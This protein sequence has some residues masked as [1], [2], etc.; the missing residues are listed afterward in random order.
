MTPP[1]RKGRYSI[2]TGHLFLYRC[3]TLCAS[4]ENGDMQSKKNSSFLAAMFF[5]VRTDLVRCAA[6]LHQ[7][8]RLAQ[9]R[10]GHTCSMP[11][12][13]WSLRSQLGGYSS[14]AK[15]YIPVCTCMYIVHTRI[16][17]CVLRGMSTRLRPSIFHSN[18]VRH[19]LKDCRH[20]RIDDC[21][22]VLEHPG[23]QPRPV[24]NVHRKIPICPASGGHEHLQCGVYEPRAPCTC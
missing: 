15:V 7:A 13:L 5:G 22:Q 18:R 2:V 14:C 11:V 1:R 19:A 23:T 10:R 8:R 9:R 12:E 16:Y 24:P 6:S 17:I 20:C 21:H 3:N 4:K